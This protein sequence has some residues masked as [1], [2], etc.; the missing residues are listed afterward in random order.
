[1]IYWLVI[2]YFAAERINK[3]QIFNNELKKTVVSCV[4]VIILVTVDYHL[5]AGQQ[6]VPLLSKLLCPHDATFNQA[7]SQAVD[8]WNSENVS[9]VLAMR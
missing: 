4:F 9:R 6:A 5:A 2:S 3:V 1:M 7:A 8:L